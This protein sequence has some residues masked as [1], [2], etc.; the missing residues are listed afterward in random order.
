MAAPPDP[1]L[2][3]P[4]RTMEDLLEPFVSAQKPPSEYRIGAEAEKLGLSTRTFS[5]L[6]YEGERSVVRVMRELVGRFGWS[7][8]G[9]GGPLLALV[10]DGASVTLEPGAQFELSGSPLGD[11]HAVSAQLVEH[12]AELTAISRTLEEETGEGIHWLGLGFQ[13]IARQED[14]GWVPKPR[15][16]VMK[17]YLPTR[18]R[19]GLDMMRRTATV[20][21]NF[22][23]ETEEF[24]LR[25]LRV[26][27]R[28]APF[29]TAMVANSPFYEGAPWG[30]KS[31]RARVWLDVDPSR[32]GLLHPV[33]SGAG[34]FA[35]YVDWALDAPMFLLLRDGKVVENTGQT[36]RS[37]MK[38]GHDGHAATQE[39][40][41]THLNSLF[42]DVRLKRTLEVRGGDSLPAPLVVAPAALYTGIFYDPRA[43]SEVES[44]VESF[45]FD[46]LDALRSAV[47]EQG[48]HAPFRGRPAGEVAQR[49]LEAA[50]GGL[51]R[52][53]R[54]R[55]DGSDETVYLRPLMDLT[56]R[57]RS[58]ADEL[59]DTY[60]AAGGGEAGVRRAILGT[61]GA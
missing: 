33:L 14:L 41:V 28:T 44:L 25:A 56:A 38:D 9:D 5:P 53:D 43:L 52:R 10:K 27:L 39:D 18:G 37:F 29:F 24:A 60:Q 11:L 7:V 34:G 48:L 6:Q 36:F 58:P 1:R 57:L 45:Q 47:P 22:D 15:Y 40:W 19:Y 59:L 61:A 16:G 42:P 55:A 8:Q 51:S 3:R 17:R 4:V 20:Q 13:P 49:I 50:L 12:R 35:A 26:G 32:Q 54:R 30:G 21:A 2:M 23:Y 46:E 31:Y